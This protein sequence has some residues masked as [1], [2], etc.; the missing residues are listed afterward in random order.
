MKETIAQMQERHNEERIRLQV[1]CNHCHVSVLDEVVYGVREIM[2]MCEDCGKPLMCWR[3]GSERGYVAFADGFV[4]KEKDVR[5][6][7]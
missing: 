5:K 6:S 7:A 3:G 4:K 1:E 2:V